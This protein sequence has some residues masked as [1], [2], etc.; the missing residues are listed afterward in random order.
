ME[1]CFPRKRRPRWSHVA[2]FG[3]IFG[4]T[5]GSILGANMTIWR[6]TAAKIPPTEAIMVLKRRFE[7]ILGGIS[8]LDASQQCSQLYTQCSQLYTFGGIFGAI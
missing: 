2:T 3:G 1:T 8:L 4:A 6:C 5:F 7:G